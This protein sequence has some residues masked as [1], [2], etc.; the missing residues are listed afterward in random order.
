MAAALDATE[1]H[2]LRFVVAQHAEQIA[3]MWRSYRV[4]RNVAVRMQPFVATRLMRARKRR[5]ELSSD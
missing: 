4:R 1:D 5:A 3:G 2:A